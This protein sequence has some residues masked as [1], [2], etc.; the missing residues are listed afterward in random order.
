M[1]TETKNK[2]TDKAVGQI[3]AVAAKLAAL[4]KSMTVLVPLT[5]AER[6]EHRFTSIG[7]KKLRRL[8]NRVE[9]ARQRQELLPPAF[10]MAKLE[11]DI[12]LTLALGECLSVLEGLRMAIRDT[13]LAAG[14]R[15]GVAAATA[16]GYI[17]V[18][19]T[20]ARRVKRTVEAGSPGADQA[21]VTGT[22]PAE[23]PK[24]AEPAVGIEPPGPSL[25]PAD[26]AA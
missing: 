24:P 11:Q 19:S 15:A 6:R 21:A 8:E 7:L 26:K 23:V 4:R 16:Y 18:A 5:E 10:D 25:T 12:A 20:S 17:K 1:K 22:E 14:N 2:S 13:Q 3:R 9:A